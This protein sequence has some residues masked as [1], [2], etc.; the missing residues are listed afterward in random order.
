MAP[1]TISIH[2]HTTRF[3]PQPDVFIRTS[4]GTRIPAHAGI[5]ASMSPVFDNFIDRPRKHRSSE[6][7]IQIHGVP[8]DAVTAFVGFLYSSRLVYTHITLIN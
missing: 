6:R 2:Y 7:I 4:H 5:L 3:L 8:C 1:Q